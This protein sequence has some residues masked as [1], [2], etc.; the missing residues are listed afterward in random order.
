[1]DASTPDPFTSGCVRR[2]SAR[3]AVRISV[4]DAD[5]ATPRRS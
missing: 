3:Y 4:A 1:M 5:R 2:A